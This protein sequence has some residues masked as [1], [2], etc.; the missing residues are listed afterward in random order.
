MVLLI[1]FFLFFASSRESCQDWKNFRL[2]QKSYILQ[3]KSQALVRYEHGQAS[4]RNTEIGETAA[5]YYQHV[6]NESVASVCYALS[7][8]V[9]L[10]VEVLCLLNTCIYVSM[11]IINFCE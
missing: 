2:K 7:R 6:P 9:V 4:S 5:L 11:V 8:V 3:K 10:L 1:F